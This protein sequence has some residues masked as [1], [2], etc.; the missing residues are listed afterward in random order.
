MVDESRP[1]VE[2][3]TTKQKELLESLDAKG[4]REAVI[5]GHGYLEDALCAMLD[6]FFIENAK[7]TAKR[8]LPGSFDNRCDLA[9]ALGFLGPNMLAD[10][11]RLGHIRNLFAHR[12]Q[13]LRFS[14]PEIEKTCGA[15]VHGELIADGQ[16]LDAR[17]RYLKVIG[18]LSTH[19]LGRVSG[20]RH[21]DRGNDFRWAAWDT[22]S[23]LVVAERD[24]EQD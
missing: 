5:I 1:G 9:Y 19:M 7:K 4:D 12:W 14:S 3:L 22:P 20:L 18:L 13:T 6:A 10:L 24:K 8:A 15:L 21:L 17:Q 11:R 16:V 23:S 2:D